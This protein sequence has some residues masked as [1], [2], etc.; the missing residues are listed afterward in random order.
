MSKQINITDELYET[1]DK[2]KAGKMNSF[3]R[4]LRFVLT[5]HEPQ[6][7]KREMNNR[8]TIL[9]NNLPRE[10]SSGTLDTCLIFAQLLTQI[11]N[12]PE[13]IRTKFENELLAKMLNLR[14]EY[15]ITCGELA[16]AYKYKE[17][18]KPADNMSYNHEFVK[19]PGSKRWKGVYK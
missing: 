10:V 9:C 11:M 13:E 6:S 1:L 7:L 12:A 14:N 3:S 4:V 18:M 17:I 8:M 16:E 5:H 15:F 2:M 19:T